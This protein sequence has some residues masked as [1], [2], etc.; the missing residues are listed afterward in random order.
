MSHVS[1]GSFDILHIAAV[2][3]PVRHVD[4]RGERV[5]SVQVTRQVGGHMSI[6]KL[7]L[8]TDETGASALA[9]MRIGARQWKVHLQPVMQVD[10]SDPSDLS[11]GKEPA[12]TA[13]YTIC[14]RTGT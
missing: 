9:L 6:S 10:Q 5:V 3:E 14:A 13:N 1:G 4:R 8:Q 2:V 11:G 12:T 7:H